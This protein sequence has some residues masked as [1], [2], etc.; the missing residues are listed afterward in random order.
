MQGRPITDEEFE[1]M[2]KAV[3]AEVG[4]AVAPQ[5]HNYVRG[6]W[7]SGRRPALDGAKVVVVAGPSA[8]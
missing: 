1:R 2:L 6:L 8:K 5:W 4:T 3:P 7:G